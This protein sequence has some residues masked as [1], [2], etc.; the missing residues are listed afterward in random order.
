MAAR[1]A[2]DRTMTL[3]DGRTLGFA[4]YGDPRGRAVIGFHGTPGS[5]L[6]LRIADGTAR[7][8]GVRLIAPDRP[9][10]GLS[11]PMPE[12]RY[13]DFARDVEALLDHLGVERVALAGVSGGGPYA[14]A[15]AASMPERISHALLVSG[16]APVVGPDATPGLSRRHRI[17]FAWGARAPRLL[18]ALT[19]YAQRVW[20][21]DPDAV[22]RR[23]V[24]M[25]PPVD[26]AIMTRPAVREVLIAA[27][28]DA[29][30]R[31]GGPAATE[32]AL[33][34]RPWGFRLQDVRV[35]VGLW[36]GE[37]DRLVPVRMGRHMA[38][39]LPDCRA[40]FIP[41]AGHYWVFDHLETLIGA[42]AESGGPVILS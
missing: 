4:E 20:K 12:R 28:R 9:G 21:R 42:A 13:P 19:G 33:F 41:A 40:S 36:H 11:D 39:L 29:F 32:I 18:R 35:P 16:V 27:L 3:K 2:S 31:G 38:G 15:C 1:T 37:G 24:A 8:Q 30:R 26:R 17:I 22:F 5:R 25:N 14:L 23:I 34:G 7:A 10:F 6:M